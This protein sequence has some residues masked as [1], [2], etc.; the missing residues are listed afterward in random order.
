MQKRFEKVADQ[1]LKG[2]WEEEPVEA[3]YLGIHNFD[4]VLARTDEKSRKAYLEQKKHFLKTLEEFHQRQD[5][6]NKQQQID[7]KLLD[8]HIKTKIHSEEALKLW[9]RRADLYPQEALYGVYLLIIRDSLPEEDKNKAILNRIRETPRV[10][11]EGMKNLGQG[12]NIPLVWTEIGLDMT[13]SAKP[14]SRELSP[15]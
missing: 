6:I 4:N 5:E 1:I 7:L 10:L 11:E 3:T 15:K 9:N 14:F 13:R 8:A 12:E 2:L